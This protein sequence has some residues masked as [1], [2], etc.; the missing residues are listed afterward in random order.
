MS[1]CVKAPYAFLSPLPTAMQ[2]MA[3][4]AF[5]AAVSPCPFQIVGPSAATC[6]AAAALKRSAARFAPLC[7]TSAA[8]LDR[9]IKEILLREPFIIDEQGRP[10]MIAEPSEEQMILLAGNKLRFPR[11]EAIHRLL[12]KGRDPGDLTAIDNGP[13]DIPNLACAL[14]RMG[15]R[16]TV[17]E[18][19]HVRARDH[20]RLIDKVMPEIAHLITHAV[21]L[22]E[23]DT[24]GS[25]DIVYW[26]NPTPC[27][28]SR[29]AL[30]DEGKTRLF[31][32]DLEEYL[33]RDVSAGGFLVIQADSV[34]IQDID[35]DPYAWEE[36][37]RVS[38]GVEPIAGLVMSTN[39]FQYENRLIV[40]RRR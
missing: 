33:G 31:F 13:G 7:E 29:D 25:A 38:M 23:I 26:T 17:K 11:L 4:G 35:F 24:P 15:T 22:D 5:S 34:V 16:V 10:T 19:S 14:G 8:A 39:H 36:I 40:L 6:G 18:P 27:M 3:T 21:D 9:K 30:S 37:T 12:C 20:F 28:L 2:A 32:G 1:F